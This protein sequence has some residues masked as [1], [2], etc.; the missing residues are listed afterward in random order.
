[1]FDLRSKLQVAYVA[2]MPRRSSSLPR[3]AAKVVQSVTDNWDWLACVSHATGHGLGHSFFGRGMP[4]CT[5]LVT[6][7]VNLV[8]ARLMVEMRAVSIP[9]NK[10]SSRDCSTEREDVR[11]ALHSHLF[12]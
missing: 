11:Q 10:D 12:C 1:M 9:W 5:K 8:G 6:L 3:C 2:G 4:G 7:N